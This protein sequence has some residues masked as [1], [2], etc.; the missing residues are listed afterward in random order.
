MVADAL[1]N[2]FPVS[3]YDSSVAEVLKEIGDYAKLEADWDSEGALPVATEAARLAAWL[4]QM[5]AMSARHQGIQWQP[6]VVGPG[7]DG[8]IHLEW[9][10][11]GRDAFVIVPAAGGSLVECVTEENGSSPRRE[12]LSAW[13]AIDSVLWAL[14]EQ[15]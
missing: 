6:P 15:Q 5:V 12:T 13:D 8:G 9:E 4:V 10:G 3:R 11:A 2:S 14:G 1:L 7:A